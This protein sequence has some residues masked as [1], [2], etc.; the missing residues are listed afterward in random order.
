MLATLCSCH[1]TAT[2]QR[3]SSSTR[4]EVCFACERAGLSSPRDDKS[5]QSGGVSGKRSIPS[6]RSRGLPSEARSSQD[7]PAFAA[8][9]PRRAAFACGQRE[10]AGLPAEARSR[11]R[12]AKA[13]E[14]NS[15]QLDKPI[16]IDGL[17]SLWLGYG[18]AN[19]PQP[20]DEPDIGVSK[21]NGHD[22]AEDGGGDE[23]T[24]SSRR[25]HF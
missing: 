13:G 23:G 4:S 9:P 11:C 1:Q 8:L 12:R 17:S 6:A 3:V 16:T 15:R 14:P 2:C 18:A 5:R 24:W 21:R 10:L 25:G 7:R 19:V 20:P 22:R